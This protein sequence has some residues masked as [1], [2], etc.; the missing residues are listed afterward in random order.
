LSIFSPEE[1]SMNAFN[2]A[3]PANGR[4]TRPAEQSS[5]RKD[6]IVRW[7]KYQNP[8]F[9]R[10][11]VS[12]WEMINARLINN[13]HVL[14]RCNA[15]YGLK[16]GPKLGD[17]AFLRVWNDAAVLVCFWPGTNHDFMGMTRGKDIT[18]SERAFLT[19][20]NPV[21]TVAST[22]IHELAHVAGASVATRDA[23][24]SLEFCGFDDARVKGLVGGI[25]PSRLQ[26][27]VA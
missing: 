26:F 13:E 9:L 14:R 17:D 12:A 24:G 20:P 7:D 10:T 21:L 3:V 19:T 2:I 16:F 25:T 27:P 11:L 1:L 18:I 5:Q 6:V 8:V 22:W 15:F 23:E 4:P